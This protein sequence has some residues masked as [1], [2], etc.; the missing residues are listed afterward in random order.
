M[1]PEVIGAKV[2]G[3]GD[4]GSGGGEGSGVACEPGVCEDDGGVEGFRCGRGK[5]R[6]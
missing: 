6:L 2:A 1:V 5:W 3:S 4:N